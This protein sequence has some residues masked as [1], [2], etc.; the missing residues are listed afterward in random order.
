MHSAEGRMSSA[1]RYIVSQ[2]DA[3]AA[4][5]ADADL[6][7]SISAEVIKD[8]KATDVMRLSSSPELGGLNESIVCMANELRAVAACCS[9]TAWCLWNHLA[10]FHLFVGTLGPEHEGFLKEIVDKGQWV[11][12]PAGAGSGRRSPPPPIGS[13]YAYH[14]RGVVVLIA[15][16]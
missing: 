12:F 9:S 3:I 1:P 15:V 11:S 2:L 14:P 13:S 7:R 5:A 6:S 10:V 8:I 4:Q 16:L